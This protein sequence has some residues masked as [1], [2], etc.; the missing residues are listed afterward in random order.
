VRDLLV[1]SFTPTLHGGARL[2][3]YAIIRALAAWRG[4]DVVYSEFGASA[5][6]P[7]V[8]RVDGVRLHAVRPSRGVRRGLAYARARATGV[9][10]GFARGV[11]PELA[12]TVAELAGSAD[13]GRV[14]A[15][16]PTTA[17]TLAAL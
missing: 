12:A 4:V 15:D 8:M 5:P 14:I 11:S 13:R 6:A 16:G 10:D 17:A 9:P 1:S 7:E 2:R 3:T